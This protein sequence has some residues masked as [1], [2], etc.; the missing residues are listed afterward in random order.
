MLPAKRNNAAVGKSAFG[1]A[2]ER[3]A[4]RLEQRRRGARIGLIVDATGSRYQTW[5]QAQVIQARMF[6]E[7]EKLNALSLRLVHFG[8]MALRDH[9]W[10]TDPHAVAARMAGVHCESGSTRIVPAL[11][12]FAA[13]GEE[14]RAGAI[15][16]IGDCFEES[17]KDA[18]EAARALKRAGIR[19]FS[20]LEGNDWT[21]QDVF[22]RLAAETGGA[23]AR[24]G[25]SLPL[26]A[27]CE[28]VALLT[29]GGE[30]AVKRLAHEK[31]RR[32]LLTGPSSK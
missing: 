7:T 11:R 24:F 6:R 2:R 18:Y 27:L 23:F 29:A 30:K 12:L 17:A 3:F 20:F 14:S 10:M 15:I 5:E 8:G 31:V 1:R 9:G 19:V 16:L 13:E 22:R 28:G 4:A 21:A 26:G 25:E 32:L